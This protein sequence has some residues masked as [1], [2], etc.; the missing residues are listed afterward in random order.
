MRSV[1][2]LQFVLKVAARCNLN[3]S[4]CYVFNKADSS[5][6]RRPKTMSDDIFEAT[7]ARIGDHCNRSGQRSVRLM[8]HG[9]EP[10][11]VGVAQLRRWLERGLEVLSATTDV[12]FAVQT[13]ATLLDENWAALFREYRVEVGVSIDGPRYINDRARVDHRGQGSYDA[14][15][16]GIE[17]LR[18][19]GVPLNI[20]CVI[21][22]GVGGLEVYQHFLALSP[23]A[24]NFLFPD[25]TLDDIASVRARFGPTPVAE[26]ML[27]IAD[28]WYDGEHTRAEV[29]LLRNICRLILGGES[30]TDMFGN[31]PLGFVF[32]EADGD[33]EGLDVLRVDHD[34]LAATGL[35][36][37]N[38]R[39]TD[40]SR[41]SPFHEPVIFS[42]LPLPSGC[43]TC[44]ERDTCA[45][46]YLPHRF[47]EARGFDNSSAWCDDIKLIF[48]R[49]RMLLDVAPPET[50]MRRTVL[51][52]MATAAQ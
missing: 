10:L 24:I 52:E 17:T 4:Y 13:N 19:A 44:C 18:A 50:S 35:N 23:A 16:A 49:L 8:F 3:C 40:I 33:I 37:L 7:L 9:G 6:K 46:G 48:E 42:G 1:A 25:Q 34:G 51:R 43:S 39:F 45:G 30:R 12:T 38:D 22:F 47:S 20:L 41:A 21:P 28:A 14:V 2:D 32:I 11:L 36:V 15:I 26:F 27:P 5:W 31:S 29:P